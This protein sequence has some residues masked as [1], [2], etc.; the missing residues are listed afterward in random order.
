MLLIQD[1]PHS[2]ELC[3]NYI[4]S[5]KYSEV[6]YDWVSKASVL[7]RFLIRL[8]VGEKSKSDCEVSAELVDVMWSGDLLMIL[9][10]IMLSFHAPF[11]RQQSRRSGLYEQWGFSNT[12]YGNSEYVL[13]HGL[14][15][16]GWYIPADN[17]F[18]YTSGSA[19]GDVISGSVA[20][21]G[22]SSTG[23]I[24]FQQ[25]FGSTTNYVGHSDNAIRGRLWSYVGRYCTDN[26]SSF[27]YSGC[28]GPVILDF[29]NL[30]VIEDSA[31]PLLP[32]KHTILRRPES[33]VT[34]PIVLDFQ[35]SAITSVC[36][37]GFQ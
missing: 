27:G 32:E 31:S 16:E 17:L 18:S 4:L 30:A 6:L 1:S 26:N 34:S 7:V 36:A 8:S 14:A 3:I 22:G 12:N 24:G 25:Q 20:T 11:K 37:K 10:M 35:N 9:R 5:L 19:E 28:K 21:Q 33:V 29:E 15:D 23:I 13:R 2:L